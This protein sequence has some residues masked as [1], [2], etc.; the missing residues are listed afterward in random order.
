MQKTQSILQRSRESSIMVI[1]LMLLCSGLSGCAQ[2]KG[3]MRTHQQ[4]PDTYP[5]EGFI[6]MVLVRADGTEVAINRRSLEKHFHLSPDE[7]RLLERALFENLQFSMPEESSAGGP[8]AQQPP[9]YTLLG[10]DCANAS[11]K[12]VCNIWVLISGQEEKQLMSVEE[13]R[14]L[15]V[16]HV[17]SCEC[18]PH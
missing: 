9:C 1:I 16:V 12:G 14:Q 17:Y 10:V 2:K 3:H 6:G 18:A 11:C 4:R 13:A 7:G 5:N 15:D 8:T